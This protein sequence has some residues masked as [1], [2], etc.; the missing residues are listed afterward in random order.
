MDPTD[1]DPQHWLLAGAGVAAGRGAGHE[2]GHAGRLPAPVLP[3]DHCGGPAPTGTR[4]DKPFLLNIPDLICWGTFCVNF[5]L[6]FF[7]TF[8]PLFINPDPNV[9]PGRFRT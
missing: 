9:D 8:V 2:R 6:N 5:D 7:A 4:E 1:S 3:Q